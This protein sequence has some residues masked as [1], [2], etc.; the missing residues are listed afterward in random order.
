MQKFLVLGLTV[1]AS[2]LVSKKA[3]AHSDYWHCAQQAGSYE[4]VV[5]LCGYRDGHGP[6]WGRP[7][8]PPAPPRGGGWDR[9]PRHDGGGWGRGP[10]PGRGGWDRGGRGGGWGRGPGRR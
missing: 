10:G 4:R 9:G 8:F 2:V 6:G 7:H 1:L 3:F 5:A